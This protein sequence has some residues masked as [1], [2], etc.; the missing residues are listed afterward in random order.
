MAISFIHSER[1]FIR[2]DFAS[3][4]EPDGLP[5]GNVEQ[6]QEFSVLVVMVYL[7][8]DVISDC[9]VGRLHML[10]LMMLTGRQRFCSLA[11]DS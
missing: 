7:E 4:V 2:F 5:C 9:T 10:M 3:T 6:E 8:A 1:S 11:S